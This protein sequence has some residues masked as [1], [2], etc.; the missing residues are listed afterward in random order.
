MA[1]RD[2]EIN[3]TASDKTA[4][5]LSS[6]ER[7]FKKTS[8][9]VKRESDKMGSNV[10]KG[11]ID[12]VEAFSPKLAQQ[13][14]GVFG[15][16]GITSGPALAV[17][18]AAASPVIGATIS[19]AVIGGVGVG[20]VIGGLLL[21]KD[22]PR[23]QAAGKGLA[24]NLLGSLKEDAGSFIDPVLR[25]I[26]KVEARF[27]TFNSRI[28]GIFGNASH[29][30][31]PLVDGA[32]DGIE[33]ILRG[34]DKV[35]AKAQPV[36]DALGKS[37]GIVGD[38]VGDA[39]SIISGGSD[40]AA[41]AL[42]NLAKATGAVIEGTAYVVRGFTELY[43]VVSYIPGKIIDA[44]NAMARWAGI[45]AYTAD[46]SE[47]ASSAVT[48]VFAAIKATGDKASA[49]TEPLATFTDR[50]NGLSSAGQSLYNSTT[51]VG[52]AIDRFKASLKANGKTL[53]ENTEKGRNNRTALSNLAKS[54]TDQ[55]N[56]VVAVN[57]EGRK[58]NAVAAQNRAAFIRLATQMGVSRTAAGKLATQLGLIPAKKK[59]DFTANTHDAAGRIQ[60]LKE[61]IAALKSKTITITTR[62]RTIRTNAGGDEAQHGFDASS[63]FALAGPS[64]GIS[65]TGGP[66][67]INLTSTNSLYLD[68]SL[69]YRNTARQIRADRERDA[70]RRKVGPR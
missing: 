62:T 48:K 43:G 30:L 2:V 35:T 22:D 31:D 26:A 42:T 44:R 27:T 37:F 21:V 16:A 53:D 65:R 8:D 40:E 19:A 33:G 24:T 63:T 49:A 61:Q 56:A 3:V 45:E 20:G 68:G 13:I 5:G 6:V 29:F 58:S 52:E 47:T 46:Q 23:I 50:V 11:L 69:I 34:V 10:G 59:T 7:R 41:S 18:I 66:S 39:L 14:T 28:S 64:A 1:D 12:A 54:Y 32:L 25:N 38:S 17:G 9:N 70:W 67:E 36:M 15:K 55:Y 51:N 60:A 4:P 57:G